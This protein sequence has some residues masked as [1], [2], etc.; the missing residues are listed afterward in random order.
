[1]FMFIAAKQKKKHHKT[2]KNAQPLSISYCIY[3]YIVRPIYE[4][5][6]RLHTHNKIYLFYSPDICTDKKGQSNK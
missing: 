3:I 1:M 4:I 6:S 2:R 5:N